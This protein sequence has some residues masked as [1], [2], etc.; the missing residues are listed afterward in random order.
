MKI[1]L[2]INNIRVKDDTVPVDMIR[3]FPKCC[4]VKIYL[5]VLSMSFFSLSLSDVISGAVFTLAVKNKGLF[6]F[7]NGVPKI[8]LDENY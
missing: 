2:P 1:S 3:I 5:A 8:E 6:V 4:D 7:Y